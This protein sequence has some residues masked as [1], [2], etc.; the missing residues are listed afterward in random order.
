MVRTKSALPTRPLTALAEMG[1][2]YRE[3]APPPPLRRYLQCVWVREARPL[4]LYSRVVPDGCIDIIWSGEQD[5]IVAGPATRPIIAT[6]QQGGFVGVRFRPGVAPSLLRV[7]AAALLDR[8]VP[9]ESIW[10]AESRDLLERGGGESAAAG[11]LNVLQSLL[12]SKVPEPSVTDEIVRAGIHWLR[13]TENP[14]VV[15]LGDVLSLSDRQVLRRFQASVGYGPKTFLRIHR[16]QQALSLIRIPSSTMRLADIALQSGYADQAHMTR[17]FLQLA[18]LSPAGLAR[19][20]NSTTS[21]LF[22]NRIA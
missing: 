12:A 6:S 2:G 16:L 8:H 10:P 9:L 18:G 14:R 21:D 1:P 13:R 7:S 11:R 4:D 17:E 3:F 22:K 20:R 19:M 5:L 15:D